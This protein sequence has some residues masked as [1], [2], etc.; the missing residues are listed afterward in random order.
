VD[1]EPMT[2][3]QAEE[4]LDGL[5][6]VPAMQGSIA[7]MKA[8]RNRCLAVGIPAMVGCPPKASKG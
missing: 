1:T 4:F 8:L 3:D 5:P 2:V 6:V 7:E